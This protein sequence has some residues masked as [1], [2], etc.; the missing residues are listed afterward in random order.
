MCIRD[1]LETYIEEGNRIPSIIMI[2]DPETYLHPQLQKAAS[3]IL[4]R[5]SRENQVIFSTHSPNMIFNFNSRQIR[6][7]V[8]VSYTHLDVYKR[9]AFFQLVC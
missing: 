5:L 7:V 1:R 2:E 6:Q 9:Q 4:Y 8:P 3:E